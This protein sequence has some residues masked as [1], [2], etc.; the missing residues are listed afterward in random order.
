M[1]RYKH[2]IPM[3]AKSLLWWWM[4]SLNASQYSLKC[5]V[6]LSIWLIYL[7]KFNTQEKNDVIFFPLQQVIVIACEQLSWLVTQIELI[8]HQHTGS[9]NEISCKGIWLKDI[10]RHKDGCPSLWLPISRST[11]V[12]LKQGLGRFKMLSK[13]NTVKR[14]KT[15][16][17]ENP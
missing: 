1:F 11:V 2:G 13:I 4:S 10:K 8:L 6:E 17:D 7:Y 14:C 15:L 3:P 16:I 12:L 9:L 5:T